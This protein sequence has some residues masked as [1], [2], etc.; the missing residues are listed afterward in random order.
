MNELKLVPFS[1]ENASLI[2]AW[3]NSERIRSNMLDDSIIDYGSHCKFLEALESDQSR[4]YFVVEL[5]GMQVATIYFT[6]LGGNAVT[7]GCYIGTEKTIPG[8]FVALVVVAIKYS[9]SFTTTNI[10]RS[11]VA[12]YNVNPI[13]LNRFLGIAESRRF[14]RSTSSSR[15]V[16]FVEY[17]LS[18]D[19]RDIVLNRATTV[20]PSSIKGLCENLTLEK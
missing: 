5:R 9:F 17:E 6:G 18:R 1:F 19:S 2:L 20:L 8:L 3:R 4:A 15:E 14:S 12:S 11:E 7:W 10:L 16:E 13:K